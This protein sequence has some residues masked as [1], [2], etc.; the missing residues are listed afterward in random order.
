VGSKRDGGGEVADWSHGN[1]PN[2][3]N[4]SFGSEHQHDPTWDSTRSRSTIR[5]STLTRY[6]R[7]IRTPLDRAGLQP[8]ATALD[9]DR[10]RSPGCRPGRQ[11]AGPWPQPQPPAWWPASGDPGCCRSGCGPAGRSRSWMHTL[12][13]Q[14]RGAAMTQVTDVDAGQA[15]LSKQRKET[16]LPQIVRSSGPPTVL[17]RPG[18]TPPAGPCCPCSAAWRPRCSTSAACSS[19]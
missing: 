5:T 13:E 4:P 3:H 19:G 2:R 9:L 1:P 12:A 6:R 17:G 7:R 18:P 15:S 16:P 10:H 14:Q 11:A 8:S